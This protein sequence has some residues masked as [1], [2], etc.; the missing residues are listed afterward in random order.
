MN[1]IEEKV[2]ACERTTSASAQTPTPRKPK[3][4]SNAATLL[5]GHGSGPTCTYCQQAHPSTSC[6]VI[7]QLQARRQVLQKTGRC[8]ICLRRGHISRE[9]RSNLGCSKYKGRHHISICPNT[10]TEPCVSTQPRTTG[11]N[12]IE[13]Q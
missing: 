3:E 1:V 4:P 6:G 7:T 9:C 5:T 8:F 10:F 12:S 2:R 13:R 11:A